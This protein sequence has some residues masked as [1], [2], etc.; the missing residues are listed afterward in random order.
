MDKR[1]EFNNSADP[2]NSAGWQKFQNETKVQTRNIEQ[3]ES[4]V[5][6]IKPVETWKNFIKLT[7]KNYSEKSTSSVKWNFICPSL[8]L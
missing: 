6:L 2:N 3:D 4:P 7:I 5:P 1:L 8:P